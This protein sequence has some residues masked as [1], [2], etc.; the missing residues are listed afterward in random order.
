MKR[1][2]LTFLAT[3]TAC[4]ATSQPTTYTGQ[5]VSSYFYNPAFT[6]TARCPRIL[7]GYQYLP[8]MQY[9]SAMVSADAMIDKLHGG[10]GVLLNQQYSFK[11]TYSQTSMRFMYAYQLSITRSLSFRA[12]AYAGFTKRTDEMTG[13][14]H[15]Y[16]FAKPGITI[17]TTHR[18]YMDAGAGILLFSQ[19]LMLGFSANQ[20]N[21]PVFFDYGGMY[22]LP[23]SLETQAFF[24]T[25]I[26]T[27]ANKYSTK[28]LG[29]TFRFYGRRYMGEYNMLA[30]PRYIANFTTDFSYKG[31]SLGPGITA[32][33]SVLM[34]G[35]KL[36]VNTRNY[37][38]YYQFSAAHT[39]L[40]TENLFS[41]QVHEAG[42]GYTFKCKPKKRTFRTISCPSFGGGGYYG[43]TVSQS[44]VFSS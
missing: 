12:G 39:K 37:I 26:N 33:G 5:A 3:S 11:N 22:R 32:Y 7:S 28:G 9:Y 4:L 41:L 2:L 23:V 19:R 10:A 6:G 35:A 13:S 30:G 17:G 8:H 31:I 14:F 36:A 44:T 34:P 25:G 21:R 38:L 27:S 16:L 40:S 43:R 1:T 15:P 42:V 24:G 20:L 18:N 29:I